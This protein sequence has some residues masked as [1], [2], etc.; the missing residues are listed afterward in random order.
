ME[1]NVEKCRVIKLGNFTHNT[2]YK[3]TNFEAINSQCNR[4]N[5]VLVCSSLKPREQRIA[6]RNN[7]TLDLSQGL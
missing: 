7:A 4:D 3:F 1:F 6:V 2:G 5:G